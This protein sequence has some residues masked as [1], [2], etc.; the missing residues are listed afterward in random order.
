[1][2]TLDTFYKS[3]QWQKLL[4]VIKLERINEDGQIICWHCKKPI[5]NKYDCIGHHTIFL[6]EDN[7]ND[8]DI[9]LNPKLI[10]LVHHRCHNLI[11][12]K[13]GYT[14][15]E[16]FLVYGSPLSGKSTYISTVAEPGDLI[17]DINNIWKCVSGCEN[18]KPPK[19]NS[20]VFGLR[21]RL[22]EMV[23]YR[24]GKWDNCYIIGGYPLI[25]ERERI[26]KELGAREIFID[27]PKEVCLQ[28]LRESEDRDLSDYSKYIEDWW[29]KYTPDMPPGH[30]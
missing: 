18:S 22:L 12:N 20:V 13:L 9:S 5:V 7:V 27:T 3:K 1:M 2:Y 25:S 8:A 19:L 4:E 26:C 14:K 28:R 30:L 15:R 6:T 10:Q 17:I 16:V 23:K 29:R 11:H 24:V 21:D